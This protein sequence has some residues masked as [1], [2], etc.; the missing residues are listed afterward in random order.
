MGQKQMLPAE[1]CIEYLRQWGSG[2]I[3]Q[4]N[5]AQPQELITTVSAKLKPC[6]KGG[7]TFT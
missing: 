6:I 5:A 1:A 3:T 4:A 7:L 2:S